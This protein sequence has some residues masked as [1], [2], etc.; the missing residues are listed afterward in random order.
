V[1]L[2]LEELVHETREWDDS[3]FVNNDFKAMIDSSKSF[4]SQ[5]IQTHTRI[6]TDPRASRMSYSS[7]FNCHEDIPEVDGTNVISFR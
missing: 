2:L 1:G 4:G 5:E 7:S 3:L 6:R